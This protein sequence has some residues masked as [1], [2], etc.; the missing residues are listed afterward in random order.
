[1]YAR[2]R[3]LGIIPGVVMVTTIQPSLC[4]HMT[5]TFPIQLWRTHIDKYKSMI[6]YTSVAFVPSQLSDND[7]KCDITEKTDQNWPF[8]LQLSTVSKHWHWLG[9]DKTRYYSGVAVNS[10]CPTAIWSAPVQLM[11]CCR[12]APGHELQLSQPGTGSQLPHQ[13]WQ[14]R[15]LIRGGELPVSHC[16]LGSASRADGLLSLGTRSSA[17]PQP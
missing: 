4:C 12:V 8:V 2:E 14:G 9:Q 15:R 5:M 16:K 6:I 10:L 17:V 3:G 13:T 1:M 11:A 7:N